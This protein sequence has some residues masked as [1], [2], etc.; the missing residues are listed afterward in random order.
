[1]KQLQDRI[2]KLEKELKETKNAHNEEMK[3][4]EGSHSK[5]IEELRE[6]LERTIAVSVISYF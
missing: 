1:M 3:L 6:E 5:V 4:K 2:L